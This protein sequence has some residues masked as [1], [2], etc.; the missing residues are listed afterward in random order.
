LITSGAATNKKEKSEI[1]LW[2]VHTGEAL[3]TF[4]GGSARLTADGQRLAVAR[5]DGTMVILDA[6]PLTNATRR[7]REALGLCRFHFDRG[8]SREEML[9]SIR[10]DQTITEPVRKEALALAQRFPAQVDAQ[11]FIRR[12]LVLAPIPLAMGQGG[13]AGLAQAQVPDEAKLSPKIGDSFKTGDTTLT[14][15]SHLTNH[16]SIDF[17][18]FL[19]KRTEDSV[20]YAVTYLVTDTELRDLTMKIGSDDQCKVWLNGKEVYQ[21]DKPRAGTP[22]QGVVDNVTLNKGTNVLVFKVVNEKGGWSGCIRLTDK[23]G[24]PFTDFK[25]KLSPE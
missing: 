3:F 11:G 24:K 18:T 19:E 16:V 1:T 20:A 4:P 23:A 13:A 7:E 15:K 17:E 6:R 21:Y 22:D 12:W 2:D 14:W 25:V 5:D 9:E 10:H 8:A